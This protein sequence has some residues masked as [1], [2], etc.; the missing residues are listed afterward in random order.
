VIQRGS[1]SLYSNA[2]SYVLP[3]TYCKNQRKTNMYKKKLLP[4]TL[5]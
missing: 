4:V 2:D 1:K 3:C 5:Q